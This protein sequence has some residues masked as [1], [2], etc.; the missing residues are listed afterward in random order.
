[1][2]SPG[3]PSLMRDSQTDPLVVA[4]A[5]SR[6]DD[7]VTRRAVTR[8][9]ETAAEAGARTALVDLCDYDLPMLDPDADPP[10]DAERLNDRLAA[11]DALVLGT[12]TYNGSYASP[13]KTA[14][15][16]ADP[17]HFEG[18]P[19]GLVSVAGGRFPRR[20][21]DHLRTVTS[22]L[23]ANALPEQVAI[24]DAHSVDESFPPET[25]DRL[26]A[27]GEALADA[28]TCRAADDA[29]PAGTPA[30]D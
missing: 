4:I 21:L 23:G 11:A 26:T 20:A 7:S 27:L 29:L 16:Y 10:A 1:M 5:G 3:D 28:A 19:V 9:T 8:A 14:I 2:A 6:R 12:P 13:L 17:D 24:A 22:G 25:A 18:L 30:D 15:D